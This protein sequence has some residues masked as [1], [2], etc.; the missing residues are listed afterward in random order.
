MTEA[1]SKPVPQFPS[2]YGQSY[3]HGLTFRNGAANPSGNAGKPYPAIT[4]RDI[5]AMV[6][7][8][9]SVQKSQARWFMPSTYLDFD[10]RRHG[11][12]AEKGEFRW[13]CIDLDSN[14]LSLD[15]LREV[16][17]AVAPRVG[18]MIYASRSSTEEAKRWRAL[19]PLHDAVAG[20]DYPEL[21]RAFFDLV[22]EASGGRCVPDRKLALTGQLVYLPNRGAHYEYEVHR[23]PSLNLTEDHPVILRRNADRKAT[24]EAWKA[25]AA[26]QAE[27][28]QQGHGIGG[29][30]TPVERFNASNSVADLLARYGYRQLGATDHW[31]SPHQT[32]GTYATQVF[33]VYWVS[34]SGSDAN[35]GLGIASKT[36][37]RTG[38]AFDLY[39]AYEHGGNFTDAIRTCGEEC[40][41]LDFTQTFSGFGAPRNGP[42][43]ANDDE[44]E[45]DHEGEPEAEGAAESDV[46][47]DA[48]PADS[49]P[50]KRPPSLFTWIDPSLIPPR[51]WLYGRHM[52]R[53]QVSVTVAPGGIGKSSN[54]IV[55]A[56]AMVTGRPLTGEWVQGPMRVWLYNL[57]DPTEELQRRITAAMIHHGITPGDLGDRLFMDSGRDHPL[58]TAQQT[59]DGIII[60]VDD[61][62]A[63]TILM[64]ER[65]IDVLIVDPFVSSHRVNENDN[66]AI[67]LIAKQFWAAL[68]AALQ[69]RCGT[70]ASHPQAR[71][72]GCQQRGRP[73]GFRASRRCPQWPCA[74]PDD[75]RGPGPGGPLAR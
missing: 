72:R 37:A 9:P 4:G 71:R 57:E 61:L 41:R 49:I 23:G 68:A 53:Q 1:T 74:E 5:S 55:E 73:R 56:L 29:G 8:P 67:D 27:R 31:R 14:H 3:T 63:M 46:E 43:A 70:G 25:A 59:R 66:G 30:T 21:A 45:D 16:M 34:L 60:N 39:V 11:V 22:E 58:C 33:G 6:I 38:D 36:G 40:V 35:A 64:K 20:A 15:D 26:R 17:E 42:S 44:R 62:D 18:R 50:P 54:G 32:S 2:G 65:R 28:R 51:E 47:G 13:F 12:Q 24:D 69:L 10:A 75:R 48:R 52:L 7:N 19:V